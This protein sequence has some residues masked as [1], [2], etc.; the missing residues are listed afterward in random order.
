MNFKLRLL[1][2]FRQ[3]I[4][5]NDISKENIRLNNHFVDLA[6]YALNKKKRINYFL[7][8][9]DNNK[10]IRATRISLDNV[11]K[12]YHKTKNKNV[13]NKLILENFDE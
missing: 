4:D 3:I 12:I 11:S 10:I 5:L 8:D 1:I 7:A 6:V 2:N 9:F 13:N